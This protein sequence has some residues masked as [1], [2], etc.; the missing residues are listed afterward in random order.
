[1]GDKKQL[2]VGVIGA[3]WW[4][5]S[6]HIPGIVEHDRA[7]LFAVQNR[8]SE[9]ARQVAKDFNAEGAYDDYQELVL[10]KDL[11]AVVISSTPNVHFEQA[12]FA[13]EHGKHVLVEKPMTFTAAEARELCDLAQNQKLELLVS[14]PWHYTRHG[15]EARRMVREGVLGNLKMISVLMT[16]PVDRL[17][18]GMDTSPTHGLNEVYMEPNPGS[19]SDPAIAGGGQIY[20]QVSHAGAYLSF[21]SGVSAREVYA[22]F[23]NAGSENDIYNTLTITMDDGTLVN[24]ASTGA[25]PESTRNYEV[26]LFGDKGIILLELWK[27]TMSFHPFSGDFIEYEPLTEGEIYPDRAPVLNFI[28]TVLGIDKNGSPGKLGLAAMEIIEAACYSN[29]SGKS[30]KI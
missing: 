22:K 13:L 28:D 18:K 1:M 30:V 10:N 24:L 7:N 4:A 29:Q 21:L 26:R 5:T 19:Y 27:G 25:T 2:N 8:T 11:D 20:T 6:A 3:G 9:K 12:K 15:L 17:I 14:C 16:N 23:D